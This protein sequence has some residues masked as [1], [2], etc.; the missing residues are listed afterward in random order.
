MTFSDALRLLELFHERDYAQ[1]RPHLYFKSSKSDSWVRP[2]GMRILPKDL[3]I[4]ILGVESELWETIPFKDVSF[5]L[6]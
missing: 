6:W 5:G 3:E 2:K 4:A 1:A